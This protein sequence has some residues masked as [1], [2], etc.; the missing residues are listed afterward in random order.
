[1]FWTV[2]CVVLPA[3]LLFDR[4]HLKTAGATRKSIDITP[5]G[6]GYQILLA[7]L[8]LPITCFIAL[9]VFGLFIWL[10]VSDG[11]FFSFLFCGTVAFAYPLLL[12]AT[13]VCLLGHSWLM[14][15][16]D[17][18]PSSLIKEK[19]DKHLKFKK[20]D[21]KNKW[22]GFKIPLETAIELFQN[23][24]IDFLPDV[25]EVMRHRDELFSFVFTKG[26]AESLVK[27]L[28]SRLW[29]HDSN[30]DHADISDVYNMG[31][32]FYGWFL[33]DRMIYSSGI[34][35]D[36]SEKNLS[37]RNEAAQH[38]KLNHLCN[39]LA[40]MRPG[41]EH[42][43][44]GC[45]WGA[46]VLH[47]TKHFGTQT[48]GV[49]LSKEQAKYIENL[50]PNYM[51][52]AD[53]TDSENNKKIKEEAVKF[54]DSK[55]VKKDTET[56]KVINENLK[57]RIMNAWDLDENK[58][59]DVITCLE[60]SEHIG[61]RDY[62]RFMHK[63]RNMLKDDGIFYLQIAG[64]RRAWQYEDLIWGLFM[65]RYVFPG[66]DASC[67]LYW[68]IEQVERAG[69]EVRTVENKG[70]HYALTILTW[71]NNWVKNKDKVV[72]KYGEWAWRNWSIFLSWSYLIAMQGSSTVWMIGLTKQMPF[73]ERSVATPSQADQGFDEA[74]KTSAHFGIHRAKMFIDGE[75]AGFK[76]APFPR[77]AG[78]N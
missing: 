63:V 34:F 72:K 45:G 43:D 33:C 64:L 8:E 36:S 37:E 2:L 32:D 40:Q 7:S 60:M 73:D 12:V 41:M 16:R 74:N 14:H 23:Q 11:S 51:K 50:A 19:Q 42:L 44:L 48:T 24:E 54:A 5:R 22:Y 75:R 4:L 57:I 27:D 47:A 25:L 52:A 18:T 62:Q 39:D 58:K 53:N 59:Y 30:A 55:D 68:D 26:H 67:A 66:A 20:A 70:I 77:T 3:Y 78:F 56:L 65:N 71:Y 9:P 10:Y 15:F 76:E 35:E 17:N 61:V 13:A 21:L 29:K 31:N 46:M 38:K 6:W 28:F 49:T 69:F 1:M